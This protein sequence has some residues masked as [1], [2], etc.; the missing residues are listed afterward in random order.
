VLGDLTVWSALLPYLAA[1]AI[2]AASGG[3]LIARKQPNEIRYKGKIAHQ[4]IGYGVRS[5]VTNMSSLMNL[6]L[7]QLVISLFLAPTQLGLYVVAVT[8]TSAAPLIGNSI[9]AVALPTIAAR[10]KPEK[11]IPA[12]ARYIRLTV[13]LSIA[14]TVPLLVLAPQ[15]LDI[16]FGRQFGSVADVARI[17]MVGAFFLGVS[18]TLRAVLMA[19]GR[20]LDAGKAELLALGVTVPGLAAFLPLLGLK[21]AAI[22]SVLAYSVSAAWSAR[23]AARLV[24]VSPWAILIPT[25]TPLTSRGVARLTEEPLA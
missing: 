17:L 5:H 9:A 24:D 6:R 11:Q 4:L 12:V 21:G 10:R 23:R 3:W 7:D 15:V 2:V 1:Y 20:P 18:W 14:V 13:V 19:L 22:V 16:F 8:I 25:R